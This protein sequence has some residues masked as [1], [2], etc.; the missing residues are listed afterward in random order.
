LEEKL[1]EVSTVNFNPA[2]LLRL[3]GEASERKA[4]MI[5]SGRNGPT[6]GSAVYKGR[7]EQG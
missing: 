5:L 4:N 3:Y 1:E 7:A 2:K 6:T